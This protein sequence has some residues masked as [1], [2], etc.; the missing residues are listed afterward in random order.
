ILQNLMPLRQIPLRF[1]GLAVL[2]I[3]LTRVSLKLLP[4]THITGFRSPA[5]FAPTLDQR[6]GIE[7]SFL[8]GHEGDALVTNSLFDL[9]KLCLDSLGN[10]PAPSSSVGEEVRDD[11]SRTVAPILVSDLIQSPQGVNVRDCSEIR[12]LPILADLTGD[13]I[14]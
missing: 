3:C 8:E 5:P 7:P 13:L 6:D 10:I 11:A 14:Q 9:L 4:Q 12:L 2:I 1:K